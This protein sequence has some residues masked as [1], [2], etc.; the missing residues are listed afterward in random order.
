MVCTFCWSP[1]KIENLEERHSCTSQANHTDTEMGHVFTKSYRLCKFIFDKRI[2]TIAEFR[3]LELRFV[4]DSIAAGSTITFH[5]LAACA[6]IAATMTLITPEWTRRASQF[7]WT[8][9]GNEHSE[10]WFQGLRMMRIPAE[11]GTN[12][13]TETCGD[14]GGRST[15][16]WQDFR[17]RR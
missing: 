8:A 2:T 9:F 16:L 3:S 13:I 1:C 5:P 15:V 14:S 10:N 17:S 7:H 12:F 4:V 11:C 6:C